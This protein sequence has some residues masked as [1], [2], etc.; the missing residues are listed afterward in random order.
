M[1]SEKKD[2]LAYQV[3]QGI[4]IT[5]ATETNGRGNGNDRK[6]KRAAYSSLGV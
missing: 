6:R 4:K 2:N 1:Q 3:A 5:F